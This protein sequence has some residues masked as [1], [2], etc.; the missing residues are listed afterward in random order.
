MSATQEHRE[1]PGADQPAPARCLKAMLRAGCGKCGHDARR[2]LEAAARARVKSS[3]AS[4]ARSKRT[5]GR[6]AKQ[7]GLKREQ[8]G[9][10]RGPRSRASQGTGRC[11]Q[12]GALEASQV[13]GRRI[14]RP[15]ARRGGSATART[16]PTVPGN[17]RVAVVAEENIVSLLNEDRQ[18]SGLR[19]LLGLTY[20]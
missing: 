14:R 18:G 2:E 7:G 6:M 11:G 19:L 1:V 5:T 10:V 4:P 20:V 3:R 8:G 15:A 13:P 17:G 16:G 9:L 12:T